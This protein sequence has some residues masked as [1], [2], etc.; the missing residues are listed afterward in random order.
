MILESFNLSG[1][2]AVITACNTGLGQ[3]MVLGLA[4]AGA[5]IIGVN[6]SNPAETAEIIKKI[7]GRHPVPPDYLSS[8]RS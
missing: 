5:E 1:K 3:G 6:R 7:V 8:P 2:V 4:E